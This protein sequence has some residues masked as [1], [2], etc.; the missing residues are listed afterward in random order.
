MKVSEVVPETSAQSYHTPHPG[1]PMLWMTLIPTWAMNTKKKIMKLKELSLLW[2][3][4]KKKTPL[5]SS[6]IC[7]A[8]F[9]AI[10]CMSTCCIIYCFKQ[11]QFPLLDI[12]I[13]LGSPVSNYM[14]LPCSVS[15]HETIYSCQQ[16]IWKLHYPSAKGWRMFWVSF[17]PWRD[18]YPCCY[19]AL[20]K[21]G[22]QISLKTK[23]EQTTI[24]DV[25][26]A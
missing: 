17:C 8:K 21:N 10:Y 3:I 2:R 7:E 6:Y 16:S 18:I 12:S 25:Y 5:L 22:G 13:S 23:Q 11:R 26:S 20:Y 24:L 14:L 15:A 4:R 9:S 19:S 1:M